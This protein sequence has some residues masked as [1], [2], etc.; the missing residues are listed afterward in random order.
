MPQF[1]FQPSP[2]KHTPVQEVALAHLAR[3]VS[4]ISSECI[5]TG[6]SNSFSE[7]FAFP[8]KARQERQLNQLAAR[9][10]EEK[11]VCE[12]GEPH[13]RLSTTSESASSC[14][15]HCDRAA[16]PPHPHANQYFHPLKQYFFTNAN[17][18]VLNPHQHMLAAASRILH[19]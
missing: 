10:P 6:S 12:T 13:H 19:R 15:R 14:Q 11:D 5:Q 17:R 2:P 4:Q 3:A 9:R 18:R 7:G 1:G 8:A 16:P